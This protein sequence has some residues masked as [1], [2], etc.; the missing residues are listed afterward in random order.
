MPFGLRNAS[1]TLQR[2]INQ[3]IQGL[4]TVMAHVDDI[5]VFSNNEEEHK[6]HVFELFSKA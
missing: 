5:I 3:V 4:P 2:F 6:L 1:A